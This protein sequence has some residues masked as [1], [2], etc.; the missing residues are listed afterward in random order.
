MKKK[1]PGEKKFPHMFSP[2]KLGKLE[3]KNRVKYAACSIS[4]FNTRDGYLTEREY[5]RMEVIAQTGASIITNQG[6][7]PDKK[8]EGKAYVRQLCIADDSYIPGFKR[9][10][11]LIHEYGAIAIQ[12]ILHGGRYGGI[13]LDYCLQPSDTPQTLRHFN[14]PREMTQD[15]IKQCV[16]D[17]ADAARRAM[18]AGF[19]GIEV[20]SFMGYLLSNFLSPFTNKRTDEYGGSVEKRA[21][22]MVELIEAIRKVIGKDTP[23]IFR[24]NGVELMD[25]YGGNTPEECLELM[26]IAE[27]AGLDMISIVVGWHES[28]TG[29]LGRDVPTDGWLYLAENAKEVLTVPIAFG[30]RLGD[31][32]MAE[33]ALAEG[34][35]DFWEICRPFLAD[36]QLLHKVAEDRVQEIKP[37]IGGLMC[38]ARMFR[39]LPYVC[40]V[41]PRLGHEY[42]AAFTLTPA[43]TSKKVMIIGGGP[44]GLECAIT[45]TRRGHDVS[46]YEKEDRLGGQLVAAAKEIEGG[47]RLLDLLKYYETEVGKLGIEVYLN[48]EVDRK[49]C[50]K[51][52]PDVG[53]VATGAEIN[54]PD[55][56]GSDGNNVVLATDVLEGR[57]ET[58]P[59]VV[60][61]SG[62]RA[63]LVTAE[64]LAE[65]GKQVTVVEAGAK[66][67]SD[68]IPTFKW[69][70]YAWV[71]EFG[72]KTLTGSRVKEINSKGV[73]VLDGDGSETTIEADTVVIAGP[74]QPR[75]VLARDLEFSCDELYVI[76]DASQPRSLHNAIREGY[77]T[78]N[79]I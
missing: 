62:E 18:E 64:H 26:K 1:R 74:R 48:T 38:L 46:I 8:G 17:H 5:A 2:G 78:G 66:I 63:G 12:Q 72:I 51:V 41:N 22:F 40:T 65:Q 33:Q 59:R 28:R 70:H 16:Q 79:R 68:V 77:L 20:T 4:N 56:P 15:E 34:K 11:D 50:N 21:R 43:T 9:V 25:E 55:I 61:L 39:N 36:P 37:C 32:V 13:E 67:A 69:R 14:P 23:L 57:V 3:A 58:G 71:R 53:I 45:A 35:F 47:Y 19:D 6:A 31:A 76:G 42:E 75:Q 27:Q 30:P 52:N 73:V 49:L 54:R 10:A 7:Y 44:A 60:V 29:A 24:L